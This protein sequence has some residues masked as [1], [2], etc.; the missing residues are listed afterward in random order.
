MLLMCHIFQACSENIFRQ[1]EVT[2]HWLEVERQYLDGLISDWTEW[3]VES[4]SLNSLISTLE[5]ETDR[6]VGELDTFD[7]QQ[8]SINDP[9]TAGPS[10]KSTISGL[11]G[12]ISR[13]RALQERLNMAEARWKVSIL[14]LVTWSG[15]LVGAITFVSPHHTRLVEHFNADR[16][17]ITCGAWCDFDL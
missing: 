2:G 12:R 16:I 7:A 9:D 6:E 17:C 14:K 15:N 8:T 3:N 13:I 11:D 5:H 10:S 1:Y 4:H